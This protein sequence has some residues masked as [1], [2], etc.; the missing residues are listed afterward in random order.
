M[1]V[2]P[3]NIV[4]ITPKVWSDIPMLP[5]RELLWLKEGKRCHWCGRPTRLCNEPAEDQA[6][7]EHIIPRYKGGTNEESNL[8]SA[9]RACNCRRSYEDARNMKEG[10]LLGK[11][12]MKDGKGLK[13]SMKHTCLTGDEKKAI[14]VGTGLVGSKKTE[15]AL[16]E[17]RDQAQR[18]IGRL[19]TEVADMKSQIGNYKHKL[20][21]MTIR[22]L[23]AIKIVKWLMRQR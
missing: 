5:R 12:P 17:Q 18:E 7:I 4:P 23:V 8:T 9:C 15:N 6:T 21:T 13:R 19:R 3:S 2:N 14:M 20:D 11:W 1:S 10:A 22:K 16:R